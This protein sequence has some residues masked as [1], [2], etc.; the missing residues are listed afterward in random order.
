MKKK[1]HQ[2]E[3][4]AKRIL[5]KYEN[6]LLLGDHDVVFKRHEISG[7]AYMEHAFHYPYKTTEIRYDE[8]ALK[9]FEDKKNHEF[10]RKVLVHELCHSITDPL[11]N[12]AYDRFTSKEVLENERERL[13][14]HI[15]NIIL[16]LKI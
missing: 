4:W 8:R 6:I 11:Y 7:D 1:Q 14:D 15:A 12:T 13:T 10:L 3:I 9:D 2:F 5:D 16:R